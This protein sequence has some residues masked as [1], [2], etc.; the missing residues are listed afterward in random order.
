MN[1]TTVPETRYQA[2]LHGR[3]IRKRCR[4]P[5]EISVPL[6]CTTGLDLTS[7]VQ[8]QAHARHRDYRDVRGVYITITQVQYE[9]RADGSGGVT[10]E[11]MHD[12]SRT[13]HYTS[14]LCI[15]ALGGIRHFFTESHT[16]KHDC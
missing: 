2:C 3:G 10:T 14:E 7:E 6:G 11:T 4:K 15:N 8:R 9:E 12:P 16:Q 1:E 5:E 13:Y